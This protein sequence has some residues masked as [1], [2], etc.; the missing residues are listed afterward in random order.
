M[1]VRAFRDVVEERAAVLVVWLRL[2]AFSMLFLF[3]S[4]YPA[5]RGDGPP[6]GIGFARRTAIFLA[7]FVVLVT[8][9]VAGVLWVR[10]FKP[11]HLAIEARG[12][13]RYR[14][15]WWMWGWLLPIVSL[16]RPKQ[17]VNDVWRAGAPGASEKVPW[18]VQVW[19]ALWLAL[20]VAGSLDGPFA[21][22]G[23]SLREWREVAL[24]ERGLA[25]LAVVY[26]VGYVLAALFAIRTVRLLTDRLRRLH[27]VV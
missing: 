22:L 5:F 8:A 20:T 14:D 16:F 7:M 15:G 10:W 3:V 24:G 1:V 2:C 23:F 11:V 4:M 19:W 6:G 13:A 9:L 25:A 26:V 21:A 27:H 18:Q 17:M 12:A